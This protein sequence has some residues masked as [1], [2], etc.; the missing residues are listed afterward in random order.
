M[1][2]NQAT[3]AAFLSVSAATIIIGGFYCPL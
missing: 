2:L 3:A 1:K